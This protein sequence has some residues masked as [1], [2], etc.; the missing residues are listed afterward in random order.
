MDRVITVPDPATGVPKTVHVPESPMSANKTT[1]PP[2]PPERPESI[3]SLPLLSLKVGLLTTKM[4]EFMTKRRDSV[5]KPIANHSAAISM[6]SDKLDKFLILNSQVV[7]PSFQKELEKARSEYAALQQKTEHTKK[8]QELL[9]EHAQKYVEEVRKK[10]KEKEQEYNSQTKIYAPFNYIGFEFTL[11]VS[12][13]SEWTKHFLLNELIDAFP[14]YKI[15]YPTSN[16]LLVR[17][18]A[19]TR[20]QRFEIECTE[21][22]EKWSQQIKENKPEF[23]PRP[24]E[25]DNYMMNDIVLN[26]LRQR[27]PTCQISVEMTDPPTIR[28]STL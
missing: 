18:L 19:L 8:A 23:Q 20:A 15:T 10:A 6:L 5:I 17:R 24:E 21:A 7:T 9:K 13:E 2:L 14:M 25:A 16:H 28:L 26:R 22:V 4:N 12:H 11:S 1:S 27:H 3:M